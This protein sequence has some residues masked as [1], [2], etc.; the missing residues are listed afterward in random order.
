ME[1]L[2]H[3]LITCEA[4]GDVFDPVAM[5]QIVRANHRQDGILNQLRGNLHVDNRID[6]GLAYI[7]AEHASLAELAARQKSGN[8]QR[9]AF[10]RLVHTAQDFCAHTNYVRLWLA[11]NG[12]LN[13]T[14]P[15]DID[16]L[17]ADLM[18]HPE[19]R[20]GSFVLWRDW[21]YHVPAVKRLARSLY[22]PSGSHEA[23]HLDSPARGPEFAYAFAA[24][25][26]RTR[27]EYQRAAQVVLRQGGE[28]A[29]Y[30]FHHAQ[31]A[32]TRSEG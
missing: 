23:M 4:V 21:V 22:V 18:R 15:G 16:G 1:L 3:T 32:I 12:G 28:D 19:L 7:E 8:L 27:H 6:G 2:Y 30:R 20:T 9:A 14:S 11:S 17:D 26:Q 29:L 31:A 10:G 13:E 24:A 25:C 5:A